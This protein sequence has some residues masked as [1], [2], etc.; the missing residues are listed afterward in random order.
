MEGIVLIITINA[1]SL[2][3]LHFS[4]LHILSK[5]KRNSYARNNMMTHGYYLKHNTNSRSVQEQYNDI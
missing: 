1:I 3:I 2:H 5:I 4:C